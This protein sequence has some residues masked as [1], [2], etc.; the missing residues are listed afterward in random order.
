ML[1]VELLPIAMAYPF[2]CVTVCRTDSE[3]WL[4]LVPSRLVA[5]VVARI[6]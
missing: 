1:V 4:G 6:P 5:V 2:V 3:D